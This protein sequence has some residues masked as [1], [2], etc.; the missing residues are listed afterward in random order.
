MRGEFHEA[1]GDQCRVGAVRPHSVDQRTSAGR[2]CDLLAEDSV[3]CVAWQA[4]HQGNALPHGALEIEFTAHRTCRY[5]S[6]S[7]PGACKRAKFIDTL[8]AD[9]G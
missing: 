7:I 2:E 1:A 8:L 3:D 9:H 6:Y 5:F 4:L